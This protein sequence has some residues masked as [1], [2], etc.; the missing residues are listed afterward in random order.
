MYKAADKAISDELT[1]TNA[2]DKIAADM[3]LMRTLFLDAVGL[4]ESSAESSRRPSSPAVGIPA[5]RNSREFI[6]SQDHSRVPA[7]SPMPGAVVKPK[8]A[9]QLDGAPR[10]SAEVGELLHLIEQ[11]PDQSPEQLAPLVAHIENMDA[12]TLLSS[13][14][15]LD[16][17]MCQANLAS[18]QQTVRSWRA[19][20]R[21]DVGAVEDRSVG[22]VAGIPTFKSAFDALLE[23][24]C[25]PQDIHSAILNQHVEIVL[26]AHPTEAQRRTIIKKQRGALVD[27]NQGPKGCSAP[28]GATPQGVQRPKGAPPLAM[29]CVTQARGSR[30]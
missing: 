10:L 1:A 27:S 13:A 5:R 14:Q 25:S 6:P 21:A 28:R 30:C 24:G 17:L 9:Y 23:K 19:N 12:S 4:Q 22:A 7:S 15:L 2:A 18:S 3:K 20:L 29:P 16:E 26:T 8:S 11:L